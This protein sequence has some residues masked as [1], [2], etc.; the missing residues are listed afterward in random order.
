MKIEDPSPETTLVILLGA[1]EWPYSPDFSGSA[2]FANA[3]RDFREYILSPDRFNLPQENFLGLFNTKL[4]PDKIDRKIRQFLSGRISKMKNSGSAARDL[5]VYFVGHGGF[6]GKNSEYYLAV[7]STS[8]ENPGVSGIRI[9]SFVDTLTEKATF[10]RRIFILDCCYAGAAYTAFLS[11]G[12]EQV[13]TIQM[14]NALKEKVKTIGEGASLLCSSGKDVPSRLSSDH[15]YTMFSRALLHALTTG[16]PRKSDQSYLSLR[17]VADLTEEWLQNSGAEAPRPEVHSPDQRYG[18]IAD[19]PFFPNFAVLNVNTY[20]SAVVEAWVGQ[21]L[22]KPKIAR[23]T[24]LTSAL[25]LSQE[26]V[27]SIEREVMGDVKE[28]IWS[29]QLERDCLDQYH[30]EVEAAW[31]NRK[32]S[33]EKITQLKGLANELGL[34]KEQIDTI[35]REVMGDIK[36][37]IW[38]HQQ[39]LREQAR[40]KAQQREVSPR[41]SESQYEQREAHE[42]RVSSQVSSQRKSRTSAKPAPYYKD[43]LSGYDDAIREASRTMTSG[44]SISKVVE[45]IEAKGDF[46]SRQGGDSQAAARSFDDAIQAAARGYDDAIRE[47]SRT[48]TSWDSTSKVVELIQAK[49]NFVARLGGDSQAAALRS[50]DDAILKAGGS[51]Q[52]FFNRARIMIELIQAKA[53]FVAQLGGDSQ[54]AALRSFDDAMLNNVNSGDAQARIYR[55]EI[56]IGLAEAKANFVAQHGGDSQAA[57]LRSFDDTILK[58]SGRVDRRI[59]LD[60]IKAQTS[61][62]AR[63]L[64]DKKD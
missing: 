34:R 46:I 2:A 56:L 27:A 6:V 13:A 57:A 24:G 49:A 9:G 17:E 10:L 60:L 33:E 45:L 55:S 61:F 32:L 44:G 51:D 37:E 59:L 41:A 25:G 43:I 47:A 20:R 4:G 29:R 5:L 48:M 18:D 42:G 26:Q 36:E 35:E 39:I 23:L 31:A 52:V 58:L 21:K 63:Q 8:S 53:N 40:L 7:R 54:A 50:F 22:D 1:S 30:R 11:G 64:P 3:A 15:S 62:A 12:P 19:V 28:T 14:V 16:H 38:A